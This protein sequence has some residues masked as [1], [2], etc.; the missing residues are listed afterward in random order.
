MIEKLPINPSRLR[1]I[2]SG[3]GWVDHRFVRSGCVRQCSTDALALYLVLV[4]VSDQEGLS[5]FGDS[6]LCAHLGWSKGRLETARR[7][8]EEADLIAY[9]PPLYQVLELS[10]TDKEKRQ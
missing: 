3:F 1:R 4:T 7:N 10:T 6:L 5:Y 2:P 8:L 9:S